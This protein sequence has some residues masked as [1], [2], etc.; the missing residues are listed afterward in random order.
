M[1]GWYGRIKTLISVETLETV[2][3]F[4]RGKISYIGGLSLLIG[5][6]LSRLL[7]GL[8]LHQNLENSAFMSA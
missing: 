8:F 3:A 2:G 4:L 1:M 7:K 5:G 6:F